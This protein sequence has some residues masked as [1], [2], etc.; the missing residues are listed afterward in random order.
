M[1]TKIKSA[2]K[3]LFILTVSAIIYATGL[4]L[5]LGPNNLAPGGIAGIAVIADYFTHIGTGTIYFIINVPIIIVGFRFFGVAMIAK[6]AYVVALSSALT[7]YFTTLG[8]V[9]EEP[10][11][12]ALAGSVLIG[13][14]IGLTFRAGATS[15]GMDIIV[16]ILRLKFKYIKTSVIFFILD[17]IVVAASGIVFG[18]FNLAMYAFIAVFTS[19]KIMDVVLY[20]QD[21]ARLIYIVSSHYTQIAQRLL[22]EADLG[23]TFLK[24]QGAYS[25][26]ETNVIMCVVKKQQSPVVEEIVK[27]EDAQAFM[28]ITSASEIYGEGYKNIM[29]DAM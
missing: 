23:A 21:E 3:P 5:F 29:S 26:G 15:G 13:A 11:L 22:L 8:P 19:S 20:G 16:K 1:N 28:I 6:T 18:D 12:A 25:N 4:G 7:D 14:G 24:A 17:V 2:A 10:L 9:S 27:N